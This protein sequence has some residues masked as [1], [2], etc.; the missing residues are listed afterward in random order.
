[1]LKNLSIRNYALISEISLELS[2]GLVIITGETGAGKS[3][4]IDALGLVLGAR[5]NP[6][7]V[8]SGA[9]KA[10][11]EAVFDVTGNKRVKDV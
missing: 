11:V 8:R 6:Q 4:I 5:A 2:P 7:E 9:D 1:M 10:I 3:I